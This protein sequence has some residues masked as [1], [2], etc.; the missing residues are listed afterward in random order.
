[1][2][3]S[4]NTQHELIDTFID[5]LWLADGLSRNTLDAYKL[6][7]RKFSAW[8]ESNNSSFG[9]ANRNTLQSYLAE[10]SSSNKASSKGNITQE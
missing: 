5:A 9:A 1:M 10:L 6:D 4:Q 2:S 7:L 8:L 3:H